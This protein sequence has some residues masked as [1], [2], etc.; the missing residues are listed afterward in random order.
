MA[1]INVD[2]TS[3]EYTE[4][5]A[6]DV[7]VSNESAYV[8]KLIFA[9]SLPDVDAE[10]SFTLRPEQGFLR[11]TFPTGTLYGKCVKEDVVGKASVSE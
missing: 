11:S 3:T 2:L 9:D 10:G 8:L 6:A 5:S 1:S 4:L 7:F